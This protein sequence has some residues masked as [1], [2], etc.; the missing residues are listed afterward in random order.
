VTGSSARWCSR[1]QISVPSGPEAA[2]FRAEGQSA[3]AF[4]VPTSALLS[5]NLWAATQTVGTLFGL[6]ESN[7][8]DTEAAY[9]GNASNYGQPSDSMVGQKVGGINVFGGGPGALRQNRHRWR[10]RRQWRH[11][12][13]RSRLEDPPRAEL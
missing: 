13:H 4:S 7:P 12:L 10:I 6:Q 11:F 1:A 2:D 3:N 9:G 5:A 8:M